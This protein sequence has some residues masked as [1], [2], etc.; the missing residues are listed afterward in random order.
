[1]LIEAIP[2][3][4]KLAIS[5]ESWVMTL[6]ASFYVVTFKLLEELT[7]KLYSFEGGLQGKGAGVFRCCVQGT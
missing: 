6:D 4:R 1:M 5:L 2:D 7:G 3:K